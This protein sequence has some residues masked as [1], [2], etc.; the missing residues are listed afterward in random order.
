M[1]LVSYEKNKELLRK[2]PHIPYLDLAIVFV[3]SAGDLSKEY[4]TIL[5]HNHHMEY[6]NI[7]LHSLYDLALENTPKL[8][9][10]HFENMADYLVSQCNWK[11]CE[12]HMPMYLLTNHL[13]IH[14][15]CVIL[16]DGLLEQIAKELNSSFVVIPSSVHEVLI[17]PVQN[18]K[19]LKIYS[20]MVLEV[21]ATQL[22]KDE[23]LSNHAYYYSK[24]YHV[25]S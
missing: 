12:D 24:K 9:S 13:K 16:Y 22:P 3:C 23:I 18:K 25:L 19:E 15:A 1:T 10:Y 7:D 14:G 6:W 17:V 2:I 21:N 5:I 20:N 11:P 4:A 8:L